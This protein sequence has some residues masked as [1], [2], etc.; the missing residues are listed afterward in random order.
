MNM[1]SASPELPHP[2]PPVSGTGRAG[3]SYHTILKSTAILGGASVVNIT[4]NAVRGK[5]AAIL[6]LPEG[7]GLMGM[8]QAIL[9]TLATTAG[10]G[11][12]LSAVREMA[13]AQSVGDRAAVVRCA[14]VLRFLCLFLGLAGALLLVLLAR[15]L[16]LWSFGTPAQAGALVLLAPGVLLTVLM[17][18][19]LAVLQGL[20]RVGDLARSSLAGAAAGTLLG[21]PLLFWLQQEGL[22]PMIVLVSAAAAAASWA[23]A[24]QAVPAAPRPAWQEAWH[25]GRQLLRLG[26]P[27]A[28]SALLT[29]VILWVTRVIVWRQLG[30]AAAGQYQAAWTLAGLYVGFVLQAMGADYY[31]RLSAVAADHAA[32][33]RTVN[34]Q[35][36]VSLLLAVP[37][38]LVTLAL[39]PLV[40]QVFYS[41][42]F[43]PATEVLRWQL[44]GVFLRV[45]S[46]PL[47]FVL[48]AKNRGRLFLLTEV[49]MHGL[50]VLLLWAG[51]SRF[52]LAGTGM[53]FFAVYVCY[54]WLILAIVRRLTRFRLAPANVRHLAWM[55]LVLGG[56][57]LLAVRVGSW[58]SVAAGVAC[59]AAAGLTSLRQLS[60]LLP[61]LRIARLFRRLYHPRP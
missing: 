56:V 1:P 47:G 38:I 59:A 20:R 55:S 9:N 42:E 21:I 61:D 50:Q 45:A 52:G 8:Y 36:E 39:A 5:F 2:V 17:G 43:L 14:S 29:T 18:G 48:L 23:F 24:R 28:M 33:N 41:T 22:V 51:C 31:P 54:W 37:G 26:L 34:E 30:E 13:E 7:V 32:V 25:H 19:H 10:L 4:L 57:F 49:T 11:L 15:P 60:R 40:L 58:W 12:N 27:L 3:G 16:S 6:L 44:L 46:W 53:A 35:L